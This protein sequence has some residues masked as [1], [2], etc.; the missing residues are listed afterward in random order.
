M[1]TREMELL[2]RNALM[3]VNSSQLCAVVYFQDMCQYLFVA[4]VGGRCLMAM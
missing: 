4:D 3:I 1:S 2:F